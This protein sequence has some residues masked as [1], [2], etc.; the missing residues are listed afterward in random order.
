MIKKL[1]GR[2]KKAVA[3]MVYHRHVQDYMSLSFAVLIPKPSELEKAIQAIALGKKKVPKVNAKVGFAIQSPKDEF[4]KKTARRAA[5]D[6]MRDLEL[7]IETLEF[8]N[9]GSR[10]GEAVLLTAEKTDGVV[11]RFYA[12]NPS[13]YRVVSAFSAFANMA[14]L[15]VRERAAN[16]IKKKEDK[17]ALKKR[18]PSKSLLK[19][20]AKG[21]FAFHN[22][23]LESCNTECGGC[24]E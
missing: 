18:N 21:S 2:R 4:N 14:Y 23:S 5:N 9:D 13:L 6:R 7:S 1:L 10:V 12:D 17:K 19:Q 16:F 3:A 15:E 8:K 22:K 11:V 24:D 20:I